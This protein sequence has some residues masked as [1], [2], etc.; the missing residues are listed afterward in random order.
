[1]YVLCVYGEKN[2][3]F[4]PQTLEES[5][6]DKMRDMKASEELL[7]CG[8]RA[9]KERY[10]RKSLVR[11]SNCWM[12][13]ILEKEELVMIESQGYQNRK[14]IMFV[15]QNRWQRGRFESHTD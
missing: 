11:L 3:N 5:Q 12:W 9:A 14:T 15:N 7:A 4:L 10:C 8:W 13:E 1:M 2:T 6:A